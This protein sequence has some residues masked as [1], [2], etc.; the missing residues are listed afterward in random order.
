[1]L[2]IFAEAVDD[3]RARF[4]AFRALTSLND[5]MAMPLMR[6]LAA[7]DSDVSYRIRAVRFLGRNGN[8]D[9][10]SLLQQVLESQNEQPSVKE[11]AQNALAEL[12]NR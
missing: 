5:A 1:M 3:G 4:R 9:D 10:L 12:S 7:S 11:A 6:Q 2:E 8:Q